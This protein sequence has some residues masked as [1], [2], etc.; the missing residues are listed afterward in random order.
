MSHK[1]I[2]RRVPASALKKGLP[3]GCRV[4]Q[5]GDVEGMQLVVPQRTVGCCET[6]AEKINEAH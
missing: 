3:N 5:R 4:L 1:V 6:N 2:Q